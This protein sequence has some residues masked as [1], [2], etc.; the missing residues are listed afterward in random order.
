MI[1]RKITLA[2]TLLFLFSCASIHPG[3][4]GHSV[5]NGKK[6]PI[7]VSAQTIDDPKGEAFQL[8]EITIENLSDDWLRIS[9]AE[10][11]ISNPAESK[12]SVVLGKD[13]HSWAQAM[14]ARLKKD[15]YN[16]QLLQAALLTGGSIA[17]SSS[18][19]NPGSTAAIA[20]A[21]S[22]LGTSVWAVSDVLSKSY[23]SATQGSKIPENHLY[24][25]FSVPGKMF[26]RRWILFNKPSTDVIGKL[27]VEFETA[28]GEKDT[29]EI[30]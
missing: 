20:G 13:L 29:Y 18:K 11:I 22:V 21:V 2:T 28:E 6:L 23:D 16:K 5:L 8:M 19:Q 24:E 25:P 9:R 15:E 27:V 1:L 17:M 14:E 12:L 26:L 30:R 7:K 4:E 3:N 10:V